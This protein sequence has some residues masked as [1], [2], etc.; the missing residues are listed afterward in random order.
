MNKYHSFQLPKVAVEPS[1]EAAL[2]LASEQL[3]EQS[4]F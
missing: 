4:L 3:A 1:A 2:E